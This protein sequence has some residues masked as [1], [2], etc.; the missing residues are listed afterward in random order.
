MNVETSAKSA[1][2]GAG[3]DPVLHTRKRGTVYAEAALWRRTL[4]CRPILL[5]LL[6]A[7][8]SGT[9]SIVYPDNFPTSFNISAVLLNA[10]QQGILVV[11]MMLMMIAGKFD[12]SIGSTLALS[13]VVSGLGAT[14][15]GLSPISAAA[16]GIGT[17]VLCGGLNGLIVTRMHI[18]ALIATLATMSIF[19]GM[20]QLVSGTGVS[21]ISAD[22][23]RLGQATILGIE[24]PFWWM[25]G[26]ASVGGWAV[27]KTR[28]FRQYY[29]IG[30]NDRAAKLSGIRVER[31]NFF[32]FVMM[33]AIAGLA[34]VLAAA[35]LNAAVVSAGIGVELT[36]ITATV[37]GGASLKGG[38][39]SV[40]GG[41]LGV[42]F[43]ALVQNALIVNGIGVFWQSIIVGSVLLLAVSFDRFK[44]HGHRVR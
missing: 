31:L 22:F 17:G 36:V 34:G 32:A 41:V 8:L 44:H 7:L 30:G 13:G 11:G 16:A 40:L 37:L 29:F 43:I 12:L 2:A 18:N 23:A 38:E 26:V 35:R 33:G 25:V 6:I 3:T 9:M 4:A 19:R 21:P 20:T 42:L 5:L 10:A 24:T 39:G 14:L 1:S 28:F 27:A 15:W